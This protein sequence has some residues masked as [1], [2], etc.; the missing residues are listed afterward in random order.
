MN[1]YNSSANGAGRRDE[2]DDHRVH[3]D[4]PSVRV[5]QFTTENARGVRYS[6]E[7]ST[8]GPERAIVDAD[9]IEELSSLIEAAARAFAV[10]VRLRTR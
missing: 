7:L 2:S 4:G 10:S 8:E 1:R 6:A 9:T 3:Q 5:R